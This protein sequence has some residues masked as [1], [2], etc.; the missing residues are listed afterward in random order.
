MVDLPSKSSGVTD[1]YDKVIWSENYK[2]VSKRINKLAKLKVMAYALLLGQCSP[3]VVSMLEGQSGYAEIQK[4]RDLLGLIKLVQ[5]VC[6]KFE[7][8]TQP[9][10]A[11]HKANK[12][13]SLFWQEKGISLEKYREDLDAYV[14]TIEIYGGTIG[15][16]KGQIE[17]ECRRH[18]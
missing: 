4:D 9:F 14:A 16:E 18:E 3:S 2:R 5:R 17:A 15:Y 10:G 11:L 12:R 7:T 13:L 1:E 8:T 6:C